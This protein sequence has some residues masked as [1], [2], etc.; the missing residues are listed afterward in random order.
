MHDFPFSFVHFCF[1]TALLGFL[2]LPF[3]LS[4]SASQWLCQCRLSS[5][6]HASPFFPGSLTRISV[7]FLSSFLASLPQ[8]FHKCLPSAFAF[9]L[10]PY[11]RLSFVRLFFGSDYLALCFFLSILTGSSS[12]WFSQCAS[13]L[14]LFAF[15]FLFDLI[16]HVYLPG[17]CTWLP[18]CFFSLFPASLPQPFRR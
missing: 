9:G 10:S 6:F 17:F 3:R 1:S 14:S 15:P 8:P 7:R 2:F 12:Q 18:V 13:L 4:V 5:H 11:L 16:S